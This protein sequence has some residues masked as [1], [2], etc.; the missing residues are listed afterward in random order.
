MTLAFALQRFS[1]EREDV[2]AI[3]KPTANILNGD[4]FDGLCQRV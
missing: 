1:D 3:G 4:F 2:A